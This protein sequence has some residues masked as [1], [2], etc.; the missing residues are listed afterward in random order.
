MTTN[1]DSLLGP[2]AKPA[3]FGGF[4]SAKNPPKP[5]FALSVGVVGHKPD[6]LP[7]DAAKY[8]HIEAEVLRVLKE[9]RREARFACDSYSEFFARQSQSSLL[10]S[11]VTALAEGADTMAAEAAVASGYAIDAVLPFAKTNYRQDFSGE[12]FDQFQR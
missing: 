3:A 11:L 1:D 2:A 9:I 12:A 7:K 8:G 6:R 4:D 5:P 10:L